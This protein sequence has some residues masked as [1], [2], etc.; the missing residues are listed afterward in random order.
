METG[1]KRILAILLIV[2]I[3]TGI[4][5]GVWFFLSA[6]EE[7]LN[8]YEYPGLGDEKKPLSRTIKVGVLD[9]MAATG[10]FSSIG[11]KMAAT[12]VNLGGGIDIGGTAYFIGIV[13]EDT[14]EASY[15]ND[16]AIAAAIKMI[17]YEPDFCI[18]G[19]RSE[20]FQVYIQR[21]MEA[22][23][24]FMITGTATPDF[25]QEWLG[26]PATRDY[27]QWLFRCMPPN[28]D[29]LGENL[30]YLLESSVIPEIITHMGA[31]V[32]NVRIVY[33]DLIWTA[34]IKTALETELNS[35]YPSYLGEANVTS[36]MIPRRVG[37]GAWTPTD[38]GLL[39]DDIKTDGIQ[40]VI[41]IISDMTYGV[42]FGSYYNDTKPDCLVAGI[43]VAAQTGAY[44]GNTGGKSAYEIVTHTIGYANFTPYT[45]PFYDAFVAAVGIPPIYTAVGGYDALNL[46]AYAVADNQSTDNTG[47]VYA[48]EKITEAS[49]F[50]GVLARIAFDA[51][52]DVLNTIPGVRDNFF[53]VI[54]RQY[55]VNGS[56]P[57][58]PAG[59][60]Y[61]WATLEPVNS[62]ALIIFPDWW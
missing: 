3:G 8:P 33:E 7:A 4:G 48:L 43:N 18:G 58:I 11:A 28:S 31:P 51:N 38:F 32:D 45:I 12:A 24:P 25:C 23:I 39:W 59:D 2:V 21:I 49:P 6:P 29:R 57:I 27:Y 60:L 46:I 34:A 14:K 35:T 13:I 1:K 36:R 54:Y 15:D 26:N 10:I 37:P 19:F 42:Y 40:L 41:P 17:S 16:A 55:H 62:K 9:D 47:L 53:S 61:N 5:V 20:T 52:H 30:N 50:Q 44:W 56:L 22:D